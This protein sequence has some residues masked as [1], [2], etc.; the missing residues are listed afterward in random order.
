MHLILISYDYPPSPSV[1]GLRAVKVV[2]AFREAGHA[3]SV[4]TA[5][6]PDEQGSVRHREPGLEVLT[7]RPTISPRQL[8]LKLK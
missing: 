1:G 3:V 6:L 8:V 7:V 5:R 2:R 4:V